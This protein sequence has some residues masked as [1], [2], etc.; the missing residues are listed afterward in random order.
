MKVSLL[1]LRKEFDRFAG[2]KWLQKK[3]RE[4]GRL[5]RREQGMNAFESARLA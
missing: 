1:V 4:L 2:R 3:G 5:L